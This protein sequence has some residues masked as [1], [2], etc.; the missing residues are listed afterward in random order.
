MGNVS[1]KEIE[2]Y[3]TLSGEDFDL[4][5]K[6]ANAVRNTFVGNRVYLRGI[7]EFTN[8]CT[9]NCYYC[10]IRKGNKHLKRY[11]M[12]EQ[13][14]LECV[15]CG[16]NMGITSIVLQGGELRGYN[17]ATFVEGVIKEIK[18]LNPDIVITLSCGEAGVDVYK[19]W[20]EAGAER[21]LLRMETT[22]EK[23]YRKWHPEGHSFSER[24]KCLEN[25][26]KIG[27]QTGTGVLIGAPY[28]TV[29]HLAKDILF[30]KD[31]DIDMI[32]MGPYV[33]HHNTPWGSKFKLWF[34]ERKRE[35][36]KLAIK[37]IAVARVVLEDVNIASTSALD[38]LHYKGRAIGLKAGANVI[39]PDITPPL[40]KGF[41]TLYENKP[42]LTLSL[43]NSFNSVLKAIK[44]AGL[45]AGIGEDGTSP[46]Y[47]KR[48]KV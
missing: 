37:M 17:H 20:F 32:G 33:I 19:R 10:G 16:Y 47:L 3:L 41:Y 35:I 46:H 40:Y 26:K 15:R 31:F 48:V 6:K 13:D 45:V 24:L 28:Q 27:Y 29:S 44:E 21:Y 5:I 18:R 22:S 30:Y 8:Q 9:K 38:S 42:G 23:L 39:M 11:F 12:K 34:E 7:I 2:E 25:L 14:I 1:Q 36:F 4:L 43:E